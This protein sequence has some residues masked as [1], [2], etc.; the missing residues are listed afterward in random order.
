MKADLHTHTTASDGILTPEQLL[1]AAQEK[2]LDY[3]AITD[4]DTLAGV[5]EAKQKLRLFDGTLIPGVE[6]NIHGLKAKKMEIL[7]YFINLDSI[8]LQQLFA[9]MEESRLNRGKEMVKKLQ[10][11]G[12]DISWHDVLKIRPHGI[13]GRPHIARALVQLGYC[14]N[15]HEAFEKYVGIGKPGYASRH[16]LGAQ[17]IIQLIHQAGGIAVLAH[18]LISAIEPEK[19]QSMIHELITYGLDGF[20]LYY[21]YSRY[22][23]SKKISHKKYE[24]AVNTLK[25][26]ETST[27][28]LVTGGSD[29]HGEPPNILGE[30]DLPSSVISKLLQKHQK[31]KDPSNPI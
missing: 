23:H 15:S 1:M 24:T 3:L 25:R 11:I 10:G 8:P 18:P 31:T 9:R 13:I 17:E 12:I 4:H 22:L 26:L 21:D 16:K 2:N 28:L 7:G 29:W 5:Q 6:I 14:P 20:E 30:I 27:G 19:I